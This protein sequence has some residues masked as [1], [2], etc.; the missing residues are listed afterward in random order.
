MD[1]S[2]HIRLLVQFL[3]PLA[4]L[5]VPGQDTEPHVFPGVF[6]FLTFILDKI[7]QMTKFKVTYILLF[8]LL[9]LL[10]QL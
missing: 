2:L 9:L 10:P 8:V 5:S 6:V 1:H 7:C 3:V 4:H